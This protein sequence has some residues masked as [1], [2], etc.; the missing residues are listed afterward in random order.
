MEKQRIGNSFTLEIEK[1][2]FGKFEKDIR[3]FTEVKCGE[4]KCE[5]HTFYISNRIIYNDSL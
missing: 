2:N 5:L 4:T 1:G 3:A